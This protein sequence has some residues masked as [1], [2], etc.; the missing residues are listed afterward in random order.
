M[1]GKNI[2]S[3]SD[4]LADDNND[5]VAAIGDENVSNNLY[6]AAVVERQQ[7][8]A[9]STTETFESKSE[10]LIPLVQAPVGSNIDL[11]LL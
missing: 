9:I 5:D 2:V 6:V 1:R 8:E 3:V 11:S 4:M 7:V 10:V